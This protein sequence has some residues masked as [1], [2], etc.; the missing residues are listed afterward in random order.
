[1]SNAVELRGRM[2]AD[3]VSSVSRMTLTG[4]GW[5]LPRL[6]PAEGAGSRLDQQVTMPTCGAEL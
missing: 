3:T 2:H 5:R 1:M 4:T 6:S